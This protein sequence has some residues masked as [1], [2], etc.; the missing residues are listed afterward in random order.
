MRNIFEDDIY[1]QIDLLLQ[2]S[3]ADRKRQKIT[4]KMR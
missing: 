4:P 1:D 2:A 3:G